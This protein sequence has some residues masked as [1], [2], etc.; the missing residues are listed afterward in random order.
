[1]IPAAF[2]L[3][4]LIFG[5]FLTVVVSRVPKGESVVAP[6]SRC[7][8]CGELVRARDN[9]PVISWVLLGGR[10]RHCGERI[11][12][13]Y[14]LIEAGTAALFL[15]ASLVIRPL[16]VAGMLAPFLGILL[17]VSVIDAR[18][19]ILPNRIIYPSLPVSAA[20]VLV[21]DLLDQGV[22][23]PRGLLGAAAYAGPLFLL[24][25]AVPGGMG[26]GD[27][28]LAAL[29]GLVLGA[30]SLSHVAVAAAAGILLGGVGALMAVVVLR[31]GRKQQIPFG[32]FLAG[33]AV[34]S[35][36]AGPALARAYLSLLS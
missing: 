31:M 3:F 20:V 12:P 1:M 23:L 10:C 32:P 13:E 2:V 18:H 5:S 28:K 11:S 30:V 22:G 17:A 34:L 26:M 8:R 27:V 6:R 33:G 14:P 21:G 16:F 19:R 35:A 15:A 9:I 29:I 4:G 36:L 7:P 25:L 24:A